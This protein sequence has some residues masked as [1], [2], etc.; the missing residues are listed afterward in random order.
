MNEPNHLHKE[1][2]R[3]VPF[4]G[5]IEGN[6]QRDLPFPRTI[7]SRVRRCYYLEIIDRGR[8]VGITLESAVCGELKLG[9]EAFMSRNL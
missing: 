1:G 3:C 6:T 9:N 2:V 4:G 7:R 5:R 8:G